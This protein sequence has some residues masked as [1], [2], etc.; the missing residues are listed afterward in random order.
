MGA[1][2]AVEIIFRDKAAKSQLQEEYIQKFATPLAAARRGY[3]DDIVE[4]RQVWTVSSGFSNW[5]ERYEF[6]MTRVRLIEQLRL[7]KSKSL[8][9]PRKKHGSIPL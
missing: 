9:N 1:A 5:S 6:R 7:L 3:L 4:P 2:G 8:S